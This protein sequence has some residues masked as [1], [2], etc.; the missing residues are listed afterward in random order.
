MHLQYRTRINTEKENVKREV[1]NRYKMLAA[2]SLSLYAFF[3]THF[4]V[5]ANNFVRKK[6]NMKHIRNVMNKKMYKTLSNMIASNEWNGIQKRT[7]THIEMIMC[8]VTR[9][10]LD[11]II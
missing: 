8:V 4:V 7:C 5:S 6:N 3:I 1:N 9:N 11:G 10:I 2:L